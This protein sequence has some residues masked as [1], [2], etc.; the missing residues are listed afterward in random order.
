MQKLTSRMALGIWL[1][2]ILLGLTCVA[3]PS[4]ASAS[5][6]TDSRKSSFLG[7]PVAFYTNATLSSDYIARGFT[8]TLHDRAIQGGIDAY[9]RSFYFGVWASQ[10][11]F[12]KVNGHRLASAEI[13]LYGGINRNY[14]GFNFDIGAIYYM[15][16][17]A[18][19]PAGEFE[20]GRAHV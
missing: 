12:G 6:E 3:I 1:A 17:R 10:V 9:W 8:Q 11:D 5:E 18:Y 20:I 14:G 15:Y 2:G 4:Q 13:D 7:S 16:P 19:D